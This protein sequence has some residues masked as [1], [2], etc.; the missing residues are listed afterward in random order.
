M[1]M[2]QEALGRPV[3]ERIV[4]P[5]QPDLSAEVYQPRMLPP[6]RLLVEPAYVCHR[7]LYF[8]QINAER[9]GWDLGF[10]HPFLASAEFFAGVAVLPY[11]L[12]Q[13]RKYEC[14]AG[15]PLPGDPVP[16][17][18]YPPEWSLTGAMAQAG[19]VLMGLLIFPP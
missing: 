15:Y 7:R 18:V 16:F 19:T 10:I 2:R 3:P 1:R 14:S 4:F 8:E 5:D 17:L 13:C 6:S 11:K 12:G 9:Y